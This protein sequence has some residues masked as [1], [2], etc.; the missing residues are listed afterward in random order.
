MPTK[1]R[2]IIF[3]LATESAD[4]CGRATE[5][6]IR[7]ELNLSCDE[8]G[9]LKRGPRGTENSRETLSF[10]AAAEQD[11]KAYLVGNRA[12]QGLAGIQAMARLVESAPAGVRQPQVA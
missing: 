10:R 7:P 4:M 6:G 9:F 5:F 1:N 12:R 8:V 11:A 2:G 3:Q